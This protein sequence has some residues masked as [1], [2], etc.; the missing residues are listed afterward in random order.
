MA[1]HRALDDVTN[2]LERKDELESQGINVR[3]LLKWVAKVAKEGRGTFEH[4]YL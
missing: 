3:A 2:C 4:G 1:W